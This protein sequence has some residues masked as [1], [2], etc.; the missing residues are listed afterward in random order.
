[1]S[2]LKISFDVEL[3]DPG[4]SVAAKIMIS[5]L[6]CW[7]DGK[8]LVTLPARKYNQNLGASIFAAKKRLKSLE[9]K[10]S[11]L[12]EIKLYRIY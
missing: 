7:Y 8:F 1:M 4:F 11:N 5:L 2:G 10:F 3:A 6:A 9:R 12:P